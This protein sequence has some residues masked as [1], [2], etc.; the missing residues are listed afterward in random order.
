MKAF[1]KQEE[2]EET[3]KF[4][5]WKASLFPPFPPVQILFVLSCLPLC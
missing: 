2:R 5:T 3:E 4:G 1:F